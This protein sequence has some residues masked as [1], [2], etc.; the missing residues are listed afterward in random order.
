MP[1]VYDIMQQCEEHHIPGLLM[2]I[3]FEKAS[4]SLAFNFIENA[5]IYFNFGETLKKWIK[6]F[7]YNTEVSV[8]LNGFLSKYFT[9]RRGCPQGDPISAYV[10]ILLHRDFKYQNKE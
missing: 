10:F 8:Q 3:N 2:L 6:L 9:T 1:L 5:L 4:D 7:L